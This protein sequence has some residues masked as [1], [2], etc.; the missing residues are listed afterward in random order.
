MSLTWQAFKVISWHSI[1]CIK[2][3][4][5]FLTCAATKLRD[6]GSRNAELDFFNLLLLLLLLLLLFFF[7][8]RF[9][10][11]Y[12]S[13]YFAQTHYTQN[14]WLTC[15]FQISLY[16][17]FLYKTLPVSTQVLFSI[18]SNL[19]NNVYPNKTSLLFALPDFIK[20]YLK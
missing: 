6:A 10:P 4:E 20:L 18:V 1:N 16:Y 3:Q 12:N 7:T 13:L 11:S 14:L 5:S 9:R 15:L 8:R 19:L 17:V 2:I